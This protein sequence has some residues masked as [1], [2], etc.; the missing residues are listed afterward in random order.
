MW[1]IP[2]LMN[3][4]ENFSKTNLNFPSKS[5]NYN[6]LLGAK[7]TFITRILLRMASVGIPW[8]GLGWVTNVTYYGWEKWQLIL[9]YLKLEF[10]T[11]LM[12][13]IMATLSHLFS[14]W[15]PV[16]WELVPPF[17]LHKF[18]NV[19]PLFYVLTFGQFL[20]LY[21]SRNSPIFILGN[22]VK[23]QR[24]SLYFYNDCR[25]TLVLALCFMWTPSL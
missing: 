14:K 20:H 11:I 24:K 13:W 6:I 9:E 17:H 5:R 12:V 23:S 7:C 19:H 18:G 3:Y 22:I 25:S 21:Y 10:S 15:N 4:F 1:I 2:I 8:A 16:F